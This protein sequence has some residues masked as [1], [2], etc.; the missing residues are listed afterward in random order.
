MQELESWQHTL[1][2]G[3][4]LSGWRTKPSGR[5]VIFFL[6]GNG[7]CSRAYWPMLRHLRQSYDLV[8]L[9]APGHGSSES[10]G[11]FQGWAND[12]ES[13]YEAWQS[14]QAD[15]AG[16]S[17]HAVAHSYGGVLS[18][19]IMAEHPDCFDS[20]LLLDPVYFPPSMLIT[21]WIAD[22]LGLVKYHKL[23]RTTQKRRIHWP[24]RESVYEHLLAK[25]IYSRW[26]RECF[27]AYV[28]YGF[29]ER[30][31]GFHLRCDRNIEAKI[32]ATLPYDLSRIISRVCTPCVIISGDQS[33]DFVIKGLP[34]YCTGHDYLQHKVI[35]GGH[36]FMLDNPQD[37]AALVHNNMVF[38]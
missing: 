37:T 36:N 6:H 33:Y 15:Y 4:T 10:A 23:S 7:L 3:Y 31:D 1:D 12:A 11:S 30:A 8:L 20:A 25:R 19:Y 24:S 17:H 13:C 28:D 5:P 14:L 35:S 27:D 9:D 18:T 22:L 21:G 16:V 34:K 2:A 29:E 32:F 38:S 26:D